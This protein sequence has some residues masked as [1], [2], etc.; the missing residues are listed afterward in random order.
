MR[1]EP[2]VAFLLDSGPRTWSSLEEPHLR[3]C[4]ALAAR[5]SHPLLVFAAKLPVEVQ[6]RFAEDGVSLATI[7]Y[8]H[9][10]ANYYKELGKLIKK[11]E[12]ERVHIIFFDYFRA[13]AWLARVQGVKSIVYEMGNGGVFR[14][15]SWKR[16][17]ILARNRIMTAPLVRVIAVSD[18]I[19]N[20]LIAGGIPASKIVVRHL[21]VD[22]DRFQPNPNARAGWAK[23]FSIEPDE[24]VLSTSSYLRPSKNSE[25]FV[26]DCGL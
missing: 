13:V 7:N 8:R 25:G 20:Q 1:K 23:E 15:R 9:G 5:G 11:N 21:G 6:R 14:A 19:K 17:L 12:I 4:Q 26:Q 18:Y 3:L 22:T 2:N 24:I 10:I 16:K